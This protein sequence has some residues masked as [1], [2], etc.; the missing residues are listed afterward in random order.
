M[1]YV[2]TYLSPLGGLTLAGDETHLVGLWL[3]GHKYFMRQLPEKFSPGVGLP[4]LDEAK[5]WLDRYFAG[6]RPSCSEL[7]LAPAGSAFQ[8]TVWRFLCE[9]PYGETT[10]YGALAQKTAAAMGKRSMSAQAVGGA[11]ARNPIS[12]IIPC[13]RVLGADGS[14]TGYAGGIDKKAKLLEWEGI[15][16]TDHADSA[17]GNVKQ[18]ARQGKKGSAR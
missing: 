8:R 10:T 9:I 15:S 17:R 7:A 5:D 16:W 18:T 3:D 4:V 12:I 13:H 1:Y 6:G 14:L 11:V 2:T